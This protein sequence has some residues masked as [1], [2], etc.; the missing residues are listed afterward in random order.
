VFKALSLGAGVQSSRLLLESA[1]GERPRF[2]AAIMA[3]TQREPREVYEWYDWLTEEVARSPVPIPMYV[4][5]A[6]DLGD[7][8]LRVRVSKKT[9]NTYVKTLLP[10][11]VAK[12]NGKTALMGRRCTTDY[13]VRVLEKMQRRLAKV[14]RG[15][16]TPIVE[17]T[18]GISIDEWIRVKPA[19]AQWAKNAHPLVDERISRRDCETWLWKK[20]GKIAPKSACIFCPFHG[21]EYWKNLQNKHP[22]DFASAVKFDQ[23]L[24]SVARLQTGTAKL[25]GDVFLHSSLQPLDE[26]VFGGVPDHLQVDMFESE[27]EGLCG[28]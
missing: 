15:C 6:G 18:I 4:V 1:R 8:A 17:V 27:C 24:R 14:P 21:D 22:E 20:Y 13:K 9:G 26:I 2:D 10:A 11:Y 19:K 3:D 12:P 16:K 28:V 23:D 5:S 25:V 7:A